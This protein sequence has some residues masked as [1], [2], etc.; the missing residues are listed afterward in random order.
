M[1]Y[2]EIEAEVY[3]LT[4]EE[5]GRNNGVRNGYRG[6]FHYDGGDHDG[7]SSFQISWKTK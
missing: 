1:K 7:G 6:Q 2:H 3:Y 5:G 4:T